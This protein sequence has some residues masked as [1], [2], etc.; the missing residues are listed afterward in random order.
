MHAS[1]KPMSCHYKEVRGLSRGL[2]VLKALNTNNMIETFVI[3][4]QPRIH[5]AGADLDAIQL[6]YLRVKITARNIISKP[7]EP[8]RQSSFTGRNIQETASRRIMKDILYRFVDRFVS[9]RCWL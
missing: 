3:I 2:D 6:E 7:P 8:H 4:R 1:A 5:I 9:K